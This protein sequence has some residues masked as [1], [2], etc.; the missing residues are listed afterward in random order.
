MIRDGS[1]TMSDLLAQ[2][3]M[4]TATRVTAC[5]DALVLRHSVVCS[6]CQVRGDGQSASATQLEKKRVTAVDPVSDEMQVHT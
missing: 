4:R 5:V 3:I 1:Y 2:G 6:C